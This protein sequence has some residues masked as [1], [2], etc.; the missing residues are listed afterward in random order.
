MDV[1]NTRIPKPGSRVLLVSHATTGTNEDM[2]QYL[3]T[4]QTVRRVTAF[5]TF[6]VEACPQWAWSYKFD[7]ER[8][9]DDI[10]PEVTPS[11]ASEAEIGHFLGI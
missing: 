5:G 4:V 10:E 3:G 7:I 9:V 8:F 11:P 1:M 2:K 6:T